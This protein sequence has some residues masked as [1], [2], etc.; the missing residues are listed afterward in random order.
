MD[1]MTRLT[2]TTFIK[3]S[4][5]TTLKLSDAFPIFCWTWLWRLFIE[6][7]WLHCQRFDSIFP[8]LPVVDSTSDWATIVQ[9]FTSFACELLLIKQLDCLI[10]WQN[11][12]SSCLWLNFDEKVFLSLTAPLMRKYIDFLPALLLAYYHW[13]QWLRMVQYWCQGVMLHLHWMMRVEYTIWNDNTYP[14]GWNFCTF[15][16]NFVK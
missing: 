7:A 13:P 14:P 12:F 3:I 2:M 1:R 9:R 4:D 10:S 6:K 16:A 5:N 8:F 11:S 15:D